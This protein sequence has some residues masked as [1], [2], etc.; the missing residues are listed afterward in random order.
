[1]PFTVDVVIPIRTGYIARIDLHHLVIEHIEDIDAREATAGMP[2]TGMLDDRQNR[3]AIL[4]R[5]EFER[6]DV[7]GVEDFRLLIPN[8]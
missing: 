3:A 4:D 2:A 5:F 1:M 7:H 6:S 8:W